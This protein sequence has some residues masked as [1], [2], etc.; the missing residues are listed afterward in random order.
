MMTDNIETNKLFIGNL[1]W[2]VR[3]QGLKEFFGQWGEVVYA[4]VALDRE[5]NRSRW[6]WFVTFENEADA[7]KAQ[8]EANETELEW[9]PMYIDFAR[10]RDEDPSSE[11]NSHEDTS[12]EVATEVAEVKEE[13]LELA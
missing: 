10:A 12:S 5:S 4:S 11:W 8:Q 9:R 1:H 6:F 13:E 2:N 3:W 7:V